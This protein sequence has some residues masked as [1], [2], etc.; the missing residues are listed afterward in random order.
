V[1]RFAQ[2]FGRGAAGAGVTRRVTGRP[3]PRR[4][5]VRGPRT[6]SGRVGPWS[7]AAASRAAGARGGGRRP[8]AGGPGARILAGSTLVIVAASRPRVNRVTRRGAGERLRAAVGPL[9]RHDAGHSP[10]LVSASVERR[11]D[12]F[13]PVLCSAPSTGPGWR[14]P[15]APRPFHLTAR[16]V[17]GNARRE[18]GRSVTY[19]GVRT[20]RGDAPRSRTSRSGVAPRPGIWPRARDP[21]PG[22]S[23]PTFARPAVPRLPR[24]PSLPLA[25]ASRTCCRVECGVSHLACC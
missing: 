7:A 3:A 25:A 13:P 1:L 2:R 11:G 5:Q 15:P 12:I 17:T 4:G 9:G 16:V 14:S 6:A 23:R 21:E 19:G 10:P 20:S 8:A 24:G 18:V 22:D